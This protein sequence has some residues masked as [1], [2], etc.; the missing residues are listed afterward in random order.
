MPV[1]DLTVINSD[2]YL[3]KFTTIYQS[4]ASSMAIIDGHQEMYVINIFDYIKSYS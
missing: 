1:L 3:R 2:S 4:S